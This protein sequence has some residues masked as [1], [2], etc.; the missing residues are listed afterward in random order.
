MSDIQVRGYTVLKTAAYLKSTV[1]EAESK[2]M[3]QS[4]SPE[5]QHTLGSATAAGWVPAAHSSELFRAVASIAKGN[6]E[7]ARTELVNCGKW[8]A[9]EATNTFLKLL[10]KVLTP[11][12]F[13]KKLP[14]LWSRDATGGRYEVDVFDDRIVC[15]LKDM[16]A[17]DHI[18]PIGVGYVTFSLE[19][20][21][22]PVEK[23][24]LHGWSLAVPN[25]DE[26][27]FE[28]YWK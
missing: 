1:G 12:L 19:A 27:W 23:T 15:R 13:A 4:F 10:M 11:N 2:K 28:L 18:G 26:S 14:S 9:N 25:P 8:L 3:F 22:K 6:E 16:K 24:E 21:R 7:K 20:M 5:L 17:F